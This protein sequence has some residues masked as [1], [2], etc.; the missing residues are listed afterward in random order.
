MEVQYT[1]L[2]GYSD[3]LT[4]NLAVG[5]RDSIAMETRELQ[6]DWERLKDNVVDSLALLQ[7]EYDDWVR[8]VVMC[9]RCELTSGCTVESRSPTLSPSLPL[10]PPSLP[11]SFPLPPCLPPSL[12]PSLL[13]LTGLPS[14][15]ENGISCPRDWRDSCQGSEVCR[16]DA[17]D[18]IPPARGRASASR[19]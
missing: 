6:S 8:G 13:S 7:R 11:P 2:L 1:R 4:A 9:S 5:G 16:G 10:P 18:D 19:S 3:E 12:L 14:T 17:V 15:A